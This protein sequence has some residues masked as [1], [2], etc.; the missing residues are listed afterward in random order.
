MGGLP[1]GNGYSGELAWAPDDRSVLAWLTPI[2]SAGD[3]FQFDLAADGPACKVTIESGIRTVRLHP[4]GE[5]IAAW[6]Y[7]DARIRVYDLSRGRR[8]F[9]FRDAA[10]TPPAWSPDGKLL[11]FGVGNAVQ[12]WD[13]ESWDEPKLLHT[14]DKPK[15]TPLSLVFAPHG[16]TLFSY[17]SDGK[18]RLWEVQSGQHRGT[19]VLLAGGNWLAVTPEGDYRASPGAEEQGLF[20]YQAV[21]KDA[22]L[23]LQPQGLRQEV[24]LDQRPEKAAGN[25]QVKR[26]RY[27]PPFS[28]R[29]PTDILKLHPRRTHCLRPAR[30]DCIIFPY[31][32]ILRLAKGL[33]WRDACAANICPGTGTRERC[34]R[35]RPVQAPR[36]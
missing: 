24:Q 15:Q 6:C 34:N 12:I 35:P 17:D 33:N 8:L 11:A 4:R 21:E 27:R 19:I 25:A 32:S 31:T 29:I 1:L 20:R 14:L 10:D 18:L 36:R 3:V 23:R 13:C 26:R 16:K 28:G 7:N 2:G 9:A 30:T 22:D 5:E